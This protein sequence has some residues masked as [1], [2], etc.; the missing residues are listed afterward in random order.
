MR[1]GKNHREAVTL[2]DPSPGSLSE[3]RGCYG[4]GLL[5]I[6]TCRGVTEARRGAG[7]GRAH[8]GLCESFGDVGTFSRSTSFYTKATPSPFWDQALELGALLG[9]DG[10]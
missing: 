1:K 3:R 10:L 2:P 5:A 4:K 8:A 6:G 7:S 9:V